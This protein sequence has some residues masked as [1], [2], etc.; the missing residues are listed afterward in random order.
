MDP[1]TSHPTS[2]G[3]ARGSGT[4]LLLLRPGSA[5]D[6]ER[7]LALFAGTALALVLAPPRL[8]EGEVV[9]EVEAGDE[10][11]WA[12]RL[13]GACSARLVLWPE[14]ARPE[15]RE[16]DA[17]LAERAWP[18]LERVLECG[19]RVL[20]VLCYDVLRV[21]VACALGL[22]FARS[23]SLR[24]DPGRAVLLCDEP[25]G[26]VLRHSNV[27]FPAQNSGTALPSGPAAPTPTGA[28]S[29]G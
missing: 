6:L 4:E 23:T 9:G 17:A 25:I 19:P 26:L 13:A 2:A 7:S 11:E 12:A 29:A 1:A 27:L 28:G 24:V 8:A 22:P 3:H 16:S 18:V 20:A 10:Q 14:L 21:S 5:A 15:S